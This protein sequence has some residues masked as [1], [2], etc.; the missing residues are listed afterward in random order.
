MI[1]CPSCSLE[2]PSHARYCARCG[3]A[4]ERRPGA[5]DA[6]TWVFVV[7]LVAFGI[8]AGVAALLALAYT[9]LLVDPTLAAGSSVGIRPSQ[10]GAAAL[11]IAALLMV[12]LQAAAVAGL[13]RGREWGKVVGTVA[14]VGWAL[15]CVGVPFSLLVVFL[16]WWRPRSRTA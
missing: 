7:L 1:R 13:V 8:G 14:C 16:L 2:L 4:L 3:S 5:G 9:L 15:T 6:P 12:L 10:L 11:A